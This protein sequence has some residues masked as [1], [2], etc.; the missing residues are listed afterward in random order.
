[1]AETFVQKL[2]P[3]EKP[4][5]NYEM[6]LLKNL[7]I[8]FM[9][10][11]APLFMLQY[12]IYAVR[13]DIYLSVAFTIMTGSLA[14][15]GSYM[16]KTKIAN[17]LNGRLMIGLTFREGPGDVW[18]DWVLVKSIRKFGKTGTLK[19]FVKK[20]ESKKELIPKVKVKPLVTG[21]IPVLVVC[22]IG[23]SAVLAETHWLYSLVSIPMITEAFKLN[24]GMKNTVVKKYLY[25]QADENY[26]KEEVLGEKEWYKYV[27]EFEDFDL[28]DG[29]IIV[30]KAPLEGRTI[31]PTPQQVVYKQLFVTASAVLLDVV[32]IREFMPEGR[33][34]PVVMPLG[35]DFNAEWQQI[36]AGTYGITP[37]EVNE[38]IAPGGE[39]DGYNYL[40]EKASNLILASQLKTEQEA[41]K[42]F[43]RR[44]AEVGSSIVEDL[45][46]LDKGLSVSQKMTKKTKFLLTGVILFCISI[47]ILG[48]SLGWW[49]KIIGGS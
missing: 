12:F 11:I 30:T 14:F 10:F 45:Y 46:E 8:L 37:D 19:P 2:E 1:M 44:S 38:I 20:Y 48:F 18:S 22:W 6:V 42:D 31:I 24:S 32:K 5:T 16:Y 34:L 25:E 36:R 28:L 4:S 40:K 15:V 7:I 27:I 21:M 35:C 13:L 29:F 3:T 47:V 49:T 26:G 33:R 41:V 23:I 17:Y 9:P 39:W 43:K